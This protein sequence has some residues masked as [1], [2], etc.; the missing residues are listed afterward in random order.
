ILMGVGTYRIIRN[1]KVATP[2]FGGSFACLAACLVI[3]FAGAWIGPFSL[4]APPSLARADGPA[5]EK[6]R[7]GPEGL[8]A[9]MP[10][11][12]EATG[13][14]LIGVFCVRG[15]SQDAR[16]QANASA[17]EKS[18]ELLAKQAA[19]ALRQ[20]SAQAFARRELADGV[21]TDRLKENQNFAK[22]SPAWNL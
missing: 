17:A 9:Q 18:Y 7:G 12:S 5:G 11:G 1:H 13:K 2:A 3:F 21:H 16:D 19:Q 4:T 20:R 6:G 10:A 14:R 15:L 22:G 8:F